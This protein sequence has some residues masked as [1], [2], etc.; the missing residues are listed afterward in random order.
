[1]R[2]VCAE[3]RGRGGAASIAPHD[4]CTGSARKPKKSSHPSCPSKPEGRAV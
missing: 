2:N 3:W 1:V 4:E